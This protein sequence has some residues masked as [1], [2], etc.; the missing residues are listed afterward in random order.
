MLRLLSNT[1]FLIRWIAILK[2]KKKGNSI[3]LFFQ[4]RFFRREIHGLVGDY[5]SLSQIANNDINCSYSLAGPNFF[6]FGLGIALA[7]GSPWFKDVNEAVLRHQ[8]N[9]SIDVIE[10]RWFNK[11]SCA[12]QPFS[13][14]N[15]GHFSGLFM[16]VVM[17]VS[18]CFCALAAEFLFLFILVRYGNRSGRL[19]TFI[20]RFV[21]NIRKG[22]ENHLHLQFS[23]LLRRPRKKS[24]GVSNDVDTPPRELAFCNHA[25][26]GPDGQS[27]I[28]EQLTRE[29]KYN[30]TERQISDI[31]NGRP[32]SI[33]G[34]MNGHIYHGKGVTDQGPVTRL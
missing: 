27:D 21:F 20:K 29:E 8:E 1:F 18:F 3:R 32:Q 15:I 16:A 28:V 30:Q 25:T 9:G 22:E 34:Q 26:L 11:K 6:N 31:S 33:N 24:W 10:K 17:V 23:Y 5:L 4:L 19:Q 14:L 13:A 2:R 7:P 12:L